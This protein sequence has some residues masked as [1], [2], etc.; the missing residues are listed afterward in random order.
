MKAHERLLYQENSRSQQLILLYILGNT[1]ITIGYTNNMN[2]DAQLGFEVLL[3]IA[4][5]L[6]AFLMAIKQKSYAI[7]W[8]Y[9]GIALAVFQFAR[10]LWVPAEI[11][12]SLRVLMMGLLVASSVA[13][14][15]GSIICIKLARERTNYI[16]E[17]NVDLSTLQQ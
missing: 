6:I 1:I 8:G 7:E 9:A 17:N 16:H 2:V 5:S 3:N 15:V 10:L 14:L 4:L 13:A 12:G 11:T